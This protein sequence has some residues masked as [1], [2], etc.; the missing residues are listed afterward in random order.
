MSIQDQ[1]ALLFDLDSLSF[2]IRTFILI[3]LLDILVRIVY[4]MEIQFEDMKV[5][6]LASVVA[7]GLKG[8]VTAR[9]NCKHE[10]GSFLREKRTCCFMCDAFLLD[11]FVMAVIA[12]TTATH[13]DV[14]SLTLA[15]LLALNGQTTKSVFASTL[16]A[17]AFGKTYTDVD[18]DTSSSVA[19]KIN[20]SRKFKLNK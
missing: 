4:C 10:Y 9:P 12:E 7:G 15:I 14:G 3:R 18:I 11:V 19:V 16:R 1:N 17:A 5:T 2:A 6:E 13:K 20:H 8:E